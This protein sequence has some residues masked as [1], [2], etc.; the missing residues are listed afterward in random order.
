MISFSG[1]QKANAMYLPAN[2]LHLQDRIDFLENL[3]EQEF[4]D[5]IERV[6]SY[7]TPI[8][9]SQGAVLKV[10]KKWDDST[11]NAYAERQGNTWIV[12]MFGGLARRPEVTKDAFMLVV[13][14]EFGHH[15]AGF[16]FVGID[17]AANE[18]QSDFFATQSCGKSIWRQ[19]YATNAEF[20][21]S[22]DS[23]AK[24]KCDYSYSNISSQNLC[25]RLASAGKSLA[26]L[27]S[28]LSQTTSPSFQ[29]PSPTEVL[30][31]M[32]RHPDAQCRLDTSLA[33]ALCDVEFD[34]FVIPGVAQDGTQTPDLKE[35]EIESIRYSCSQFNPDHALS[36]RPKCWFKQSQ[37]GDDT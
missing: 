29:T 35:A 25:Y 33:G 7:Y 32:H 8:V 11:V 23:I 3:T 6:E 30:T 37:V 13:C 4:L 28:T 27:L 22:I 2:N 31:T 19:D 18:G 24:A 14:H 26:D 16:P 20:R 12:A 10:E 5:I 15:L 34:D 1:V 36:M 21:K 17:W 9:E